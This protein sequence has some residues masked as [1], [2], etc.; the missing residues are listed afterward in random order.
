MGPGSLRRAIERKSPML[1]HRSTRTGSSTLANYEQQVEVL[2]MGCA[3]QS[4]QR[5]GVAAFSM[6]S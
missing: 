6:T 2:R 5:I 1:L 4:D 3:R